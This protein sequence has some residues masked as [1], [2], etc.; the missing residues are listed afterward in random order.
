MFMSDS[1][2]AHAAHCRMDG[3]RIIIDPDTV[4]LG[5]GL[6]RS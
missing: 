3:K 2:E 1:V 5:C 4:E 6:V